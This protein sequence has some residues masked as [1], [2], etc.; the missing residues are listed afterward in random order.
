[1]RNCVTAARQTLTLFV[2]VQI[3]LPQPEKASSQDEAFSTKCSALAER[4]A[5]FG[6]EVRFAREVCL[7][8]DISGTLNFTCR[9]AAYFTLLHLP[10][11]Q[12]SQKG[13]GYVRIKTPRSV[14][15]FRRLDHQPRQR[16]KIKTRNDHFQPDR[17]SGTQN[18]CRFRAVFSKDD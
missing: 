16:L 1:M 2:R 3:L 15:R 5:S 13:N 17:T 12:T 7:R 4:E 6:R 8:H 11:G 10:A 14:P 9:K 18:S